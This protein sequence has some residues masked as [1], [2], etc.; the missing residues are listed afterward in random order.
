MKYH[1]YEQF[2]D[3][4][5]STIKLD[6]PFEVRNYADWQP[7]LVVKVTDIPTGLDNESLVRSYQ[8]DYNE[9]NHTWNGNASD[10]ISKYY[11]EGKRPSGCSTHKIPQDDKYLKFRN[12]ALD[13]ASNVSKYIEV[14]DKS[15]RFIYGLRPGERNEYYLVLDIWNE[16]IK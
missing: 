15:I 14:K 5:K 1:T 4:V 8:E 2:L 13:I 3:Y 6:V 7:I 10:L 11:D 9:L 16:A 12:A